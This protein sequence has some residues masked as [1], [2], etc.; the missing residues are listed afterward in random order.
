MRVSIV[1]ACDLGTYGDTCVCVLEG[2]YVVRMYVCMHVCIY[3]SMYVCMD[4][5]M[6]GWV[7]RCMYG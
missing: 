7:Y 2:M 3:E 6:D 4:G 1:R 5:W